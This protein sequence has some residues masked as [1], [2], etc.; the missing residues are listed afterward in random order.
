EFMAYRSV[1][2]ISTA[3]L[4]VL[5]FAL[6]SES[7]A[8]TS[9]AQKPPQTEAKKSPATRSKEWKIQN[10]MSAALRAISKDATIMDWP[11]KEGEAPTVLRKGTNAWTCLPD[12]PSTPGND[13]MCLDKM[14]MEW[15]QAW[16]TKKA[17]NI[18]APRV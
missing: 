8:P 2:T 6:H 1:L 4:L 10:A 15:A 12:D 11:A 17:P 3:V 18:T 13:P 9:G 5:V 7:Q 14:W 16:M